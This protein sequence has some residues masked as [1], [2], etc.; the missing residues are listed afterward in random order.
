MPL[1]FLLDPEMHKPPSS[2]HDTQAPPL[3][4]GQGIEPDVSDKIL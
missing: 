1:L 3:S 4:V 2:F